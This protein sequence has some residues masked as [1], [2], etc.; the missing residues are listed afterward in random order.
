LKAVAIP[1]NEIRLTSKV[2]IMFVVIKLPDAV[3]GKIE[4]AARAHAPHRIIDPSDQ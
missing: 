3:F 1:R 2:P 4:N